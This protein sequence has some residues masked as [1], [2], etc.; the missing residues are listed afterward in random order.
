MI[1]VLHI[2]HPNQI[3]VRG[4]EMRV[5][6]KEVIDKPLWPV[7]RRDRRGWWCE[8][9]PRASYAALQAMVLVTVDR[10]V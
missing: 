4:K 1:I 6:A 2:L 8:S 3:I 7:S 5:N 10:N 9:F